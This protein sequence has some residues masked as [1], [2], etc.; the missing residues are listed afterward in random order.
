MR[1]CLLLI[2]A[3]IIPTARS[4]QTPSYT[5]RRATSSITIDG[6]LDEPAWFAAPDT[7]TFQFPWWKSGRKERTRAKLLWDDKNLYVSHIAEDEFITARHRERDG[8]I[9]EDDCFEIM[10][11]PNPATPE[12]YFNLEWNVIGGLVD[13]FRPD[14]PGKPRAPVWNAEGVEIAGQ[15]SGTLNDDSDH[16][17]YWQ[18]EVKIPFSNFAK[19]A[20]RVPPASGGVWKMNLNRHG[21]KVNGQFSQWSP[22]DTSSP[23]FH[24]PHRFG[25]LI[26]SGAPF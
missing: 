7:G 5:A 20:V 6:K 25:S 11:A 4:G 15:Y 13:N 24:T 22:G 10:I 1:V 2:C 16:D 8:K 12:V 21:G 14:G 26:F 18:V 23:N 19:V 3:I 17:R 9:F